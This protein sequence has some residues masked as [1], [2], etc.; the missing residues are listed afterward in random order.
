[1]RFIIEYSITVHV[2]NVGAILLSENTSVSQRINHI[3]VLHYFICYYVEDVSVQIKFDCSHE[4]RT[5]QYTKYLSNG[6]FKLLTSRFL[7]HN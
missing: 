5:N 3:D 7:H 2:Y 1:M 6:L 4:N